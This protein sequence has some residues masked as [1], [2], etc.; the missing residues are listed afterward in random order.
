MS[1]TYRMFSVGL[2]GSRRSMLKILK[3]LET[4]ECSVTAVNSVNK[5]RR[6]RNGGAATKNTY[7][8]IT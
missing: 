7:V 6:S 1:F 3:G 8:K 4:W 5:F 2:H